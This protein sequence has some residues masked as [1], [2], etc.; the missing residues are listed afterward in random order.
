MYLLLGPAGLKYSHDFF[1]TNNLLQAMLKYV[2]PKFVLLSDRWLNVSM[3]DDTER[4]NVLKWKAILLLTVTTP[5]NYT[6]TLLKVQNPANSCTL[7][8][9][10]LAF[11]LGFVLLKLY[12]LPYHIISVKIM[13]ETYPIMIIFNT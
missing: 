11:T 9:H 4:S 12:V 5:F 2:K 13:A 7:Y 3:T 6:Q 10:Q 1:F 8:Y